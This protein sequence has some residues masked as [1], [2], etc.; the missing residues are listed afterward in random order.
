VHNLGGTAGC[1]L[2]SRLSEDPDVSVLVIEK[3]HVKDNIIS[4]MPLISQ[5]MFLGDLLQVV[6]DRW[7]D[8]M[9]GANGRRNRLWAVE[10]IGGAS[11]MNAMLWT[12]GYPGDYAAWAE[13][14]L[15]EWT[16]EKMEPYFQ[17]IENAV[18]HP[19]S[20]F[21]GHKG[22]HPHTKSPRNQL[23]PNQPEQGPMELRQYQFPFAW[24][25]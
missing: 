11:R 24:T 14:G 25:K 23:C 8:R 17:R 5:N 2:A 10:G 19:N 1:V 21:R 13:L 4:R 12:R 9:P 18:C 20:S 3:G 7:S 6:S 16:Y 15:D 22:S